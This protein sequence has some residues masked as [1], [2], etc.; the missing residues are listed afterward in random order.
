MLET[1]RVLDEAEVWPELFFLFFFLS[2]FP[3]FHFLLVLLQLRGELLQLR[4]AQGLVPDVQKQARLEAAVQNRQRAGKVARGGAV[5]H[6]S[7]PR[8]SEQPPVGVQEHGRNAVLQLKHGGAD[9][10]QDLDSSSVKGSDPFEGGS[11]RQ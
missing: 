4:V 6:S 10:A 2:P 8:F 1:Q 9:Q 3:L 11:V 7:D 5:A